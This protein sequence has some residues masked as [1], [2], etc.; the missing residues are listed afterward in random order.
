MF[1]TKITKYQG[2][3]N[4]SLVTRCWLI[5]SQLIHRLGVPMKF[6]DRVENSLCHFYDN[7]PIYWIWAM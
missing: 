6:E 3:K 7:I 2:V 4:F 1:T 5:K